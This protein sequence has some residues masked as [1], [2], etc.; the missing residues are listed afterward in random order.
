MAE[1]VTLSAVAAHAGVSRATASLVLRGTGRV[2]A[3]TRQRVLA[4]MTEL[5]YVYDRVAASMRTQ[6]T[7]VVGVMISNIANAFFAELLLGLEAELGAVGYLPLLAHTGSDLE[8]QDEML[9]VLR[10][11]RVAGLAIAP[12]TGTQPAFIERLQ[13][14]RIGHVLLTLQVDGITTSFVGPDDVRGGELAAEHLIEVHGCRTLLFLGGTAG[15]ANRR[16]RLAG[17]RA[18]AAAG[19]LPKSAVTQLRATVGDPIGAA[20][21]QQVIAAGALPDGIV[22][23]SDVTAMGLY[24]ALRDAGVDDQVHVTGYDDI[25]AAALWEPPLTTVATHADDLGRRAA[26]LL[27][28]RLVDP[29]ALPVIDRVAP[30]LVVRRSCGC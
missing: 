7:P 5:G 25:P 27:G 3:E 14:W 15:A 23:A 30:E 8:R 20:L 21:G 2:S 28:Q 26:R 4:S 13:S 6:H 17:V 11:H 19:G 16:D 1:R 18:A 24:R 9:R 29:S 12:V 22:C 10:E